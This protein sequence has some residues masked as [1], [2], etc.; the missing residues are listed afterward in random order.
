[1]IHINFYPYFLFYY[2]CTIA[3]WQLQF[4][5]YVKVCYYTIK[6]ES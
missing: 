4:N 3:V 5:E 1:M 2:Y 6:D